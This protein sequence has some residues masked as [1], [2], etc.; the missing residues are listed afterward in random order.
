M[1]ARHHG[2][3]IAERFITPTATMRGSMRSI[4]Q[5]LNRK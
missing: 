4:D 1:A 3:R 5:V 2:V